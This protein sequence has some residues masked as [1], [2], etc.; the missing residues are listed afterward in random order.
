MEETDYFSQ[1]FKSI[2]KGLKSISPD[3]LDQAAYMVWKTHKS[4]KKIIV[5]GNGG[6][7]AM[8]SHVCVDFTKAAGIRAI[9]FNEADLITCFANDYGYEHWVAKALEAYSDSGD[10][11]ILISSSGKSKNILNA[12]E[13]AKSIGLSVITVSGFLQDNPLRK[14]GNLNLWADSSEY[15]IVEM[16]HHIWLVAI[17]DFLIKKEVKK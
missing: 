13:K 15:N 3:Q 4:G 1:Y 12:A 14:I 5:V 6:S 17:I 11:A 7:A 10:L 8:A 9:N 16:T 2:S